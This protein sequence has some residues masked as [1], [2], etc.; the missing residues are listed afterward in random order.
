MMIQSNV[1]F[2]GYKLSKI[3]K[4]LKEMQLEKVFLSTAILLIITELGF[5]L[6]SSLI[7]VSVISE[8]YN[9]LLSEYKKNTAKSFLKQGV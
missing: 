3:E 1:A 5:K 6:S 8:L 2:K 9:V 7:L 4:V